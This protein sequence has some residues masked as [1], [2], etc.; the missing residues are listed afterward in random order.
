[1]RIKK[2]VIEIDNGD[3]YTTEIDDGSTFCSDCSLHELCTGEDGLILESVCNNS[4]CNY[5]WVK[6]DRKRD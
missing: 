1:M 4:D 3:I 2:L 6:Y 5:K